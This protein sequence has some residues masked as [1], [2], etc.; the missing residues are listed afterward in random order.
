MREEVG[1][2]VGKRVGLFWIV[3][4]VFLIPSL[5]LA[6]SA[7][8]SDENRATP[9]EVA[10]LTAPLRER[11][12][13]HGEFQQEKRIPALRKPVKSSGDFTF[14]R[15]GSL[16]WSVRQPFQS[17]VLL[18]P[19]GITRRDETGAE[20]SIEGSSV[21]ER[22][23]E[24]FLVLFGGEFSTLES[25]C[26]FWVKRNESQW[27]LGLRPKGGGLKKLFTALVVRGEAA[28]QKTQ[29]QGVQLF[30]PNGDTT[31]IVFLNTQYRTHGG[32]GK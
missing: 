22:F 1:R 19:K 7:L 25:Q 29:V 32:E 14:L 3:L 5:V 2:A 16:E 20:V 6:E 13:V 18:S 28:A 30:E 15:S 26:D 10:A 24:L 21:V 27:E 9:L 17:E 11:T 4:I 12:Y 23:S 8:F 31:D